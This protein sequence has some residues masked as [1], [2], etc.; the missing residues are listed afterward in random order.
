[1]NVNV[2]PDCFANAGLKRR[3]VS[4]RPAASQGPCDFHPAKKGVPIDAVARIVDPVFRELYWGGPDDG[5]IWLDDRGDLLVDVLYDLTQADDD[6]T[7]EALIGALVDEDDYWPPDGE[8]AFY[9]PEYRYTLQPDTSGQHIGTWQA[10]RRSLM[11]ESRF[12][13]PDAEKSLNTIFRG[14]QQLRDAN[15]QG[16][17]YLIAPDAR[18]ARFFRARTANSI[19]EADRIKADLARELGP[20]PENLRKA[21]RLNPSGIS[22]FYGAFD[23]A[24][25]IAELRPSVGGSVIS[26]QFRLARPICVLD[27]TRFADRP[28]SVNLFANGALARARLFQFMQWF[29]EDIA[30][31]VFPG[32]EHLEY[33]PTQAVAEFL[34]KRFQIPFAGELRGIDA[35][36]FRSAQRPGGKNIVILGDAA[37]VGDPIVEQAA[38]PGT[39][40][41]EPQDFAFDDWFDQ[42]LSTIRAKKPAG[43]L[44]DPETVRWTHVT[45]AQFT[46]Q[47]DRLNGNDDPDVDI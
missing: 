44:P 33:L 38:E 3:I 32:D 15:K 9:D 19:E 40:P 21:G 31:P 42:E 20:P 41:V 4:I 17:V 39:E 18:E 2:C 37:I 36:I 13:N 34:N 43:L 11:F 46:T 10:F 23:L 28:A 24:T 12:F 7:L 45:G 1:M 8:E 16:P 14:V 30:R 25:C 6:R 5:N 35:V 29:M 26:A 27:T 22:A 47:E